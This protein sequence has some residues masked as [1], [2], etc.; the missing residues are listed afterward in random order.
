MKIKYEIQLHTYWHC[1]S[2][3]AAGADVK[4]LAIKDKYGLPFIPGK[5]IKGLVRE[6][7]DEMLTLKSDSVEATEE[8]KKTFG[9]FAKDAKTMERSEAFFTNACL[10]E[11]E[12]DAI[13]S[14]GLAKFMFDSVSQTA[15]EKEGVA[16]K[17]SLRKIQVALPCVLE[18]EI[19]NVPATMETTIK[20]GLKFIKCLGIG[21]YR[22]LGRCTIT[23][24]EDKA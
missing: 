13:K 6:A 1:G 7:V 5:T 24:K 8:Y 9:Y 22:G 11:K 14:N 15:I 16:L 2:G 12:S 3:L 18:G 10:R 21:R 20:D 19:L 23:I 17:N 4:A